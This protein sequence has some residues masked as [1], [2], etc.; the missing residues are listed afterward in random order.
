MIRA[1]Y[2]TILI[3]LR[4][5]VDRLGKQEMLLYTGVL[6][7]V[8][9]IWG[10]A[11]LADEVMEGDTERF[12]KWMVTAM[13]RPNDLATP[14]GPAWLHEMGRDFTALG[15]IGILV[16]VTVIVAGYMHLQRKYHAMW[17][18]L[19]ASIGGMAIS[20]I[21]KNAFAR[22]RP[23]EVP[24]LAHTMTSSFPSGHSMMSAC[25]YLTLGILLTRVVKGRWT[26]V[27]ILL[28]AMLIAGAVG[29]SRVYLGVHYPTD[30]L[31]GWTAGLVWAL[32]CWAIMRYLQHRGQIEP[33]SREQA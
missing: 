21:L 1:T 17:L 13:R 3:Y 2:S 24:H 6:V 25:V 29:V 31:A 15:G 26:K 10:F 12:D 14:I 22:E 11:E 23:G 9:G 5:L 4:S 7:L 33:P 30:V 27:Y 16:S 28:V 19:V 18:T 32:F 8:V 20:L